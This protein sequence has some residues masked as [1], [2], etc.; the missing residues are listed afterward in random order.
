MLRNF[1]TAS[2]ALL[3]L[4]PA[5]AHAQEG[6]A[7]SNTPTTGVYGVARAG[8]GIDADVRLKASDLAA[9]T[10]L[11]RSADGK[12]GWAGELGMGYS[13]GG[14]RLEA[15]GGYA[16]NALDRKSPAKAAAFDAGGRLNKLDLLVSGYVDLMPNGTISPFIGAGIGAA[17]VSTNIQRTAGL[18]GGTVL[19]DR[20]WGFAYHGTAGVAV[21]LGEK[22]AVE[23]GVRHERVTGIKLDGT[24]GTPAVARSFKTNGYRSTTALV[25]LRVGF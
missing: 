6:A 20:D 8:V 4:T 19:K 5:L 7:Q 18:T 21:K 23:L 1:L 3:A 15:T 22:S 2:A 11:Q 14:F 24:V 10:S 12:R 16:R 9:P 25:G 17:R 13:F